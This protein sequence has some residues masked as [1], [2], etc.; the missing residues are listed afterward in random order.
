MP[1]LIFILKVLSCAGS[2]DV[3]LAS[4]SPLSVSPSEFLSRGS[5]KYAAHFHSHMFTTKSWGGVVLELVLDRTETHI[6]QDFN[7]IIQHKNFVKTL[8]LTNSQF[9]NSLYTYFDAIIA[10]K[11]GNRKP[12]GNNK[13]K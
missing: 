8:I 1:W 5:V 2:I 9:T 3:P 4:K 6:F 11:I 13:K 7:F 12:V 10:L